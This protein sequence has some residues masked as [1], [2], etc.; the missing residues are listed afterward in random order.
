[1]L[2]IPVLNPPRKPK[3]GRKKVA[4][5]TKKK[6]KTK[7]RTSPVRTTTRKK[8]KLTWVEAARVSGAVYPKKYPRWHEKAGEKTG[9]REGKPLS[10]HDA[11]Q[12]RRPVIGYL[13]RQMI[14]EWYDPG[15]GGATAKAGSARLAKAAAL[16]KK[17]EEQL[18]EYRKEHGTP[19][20]RHPQK[21]K[22]GPKKGQ[23]KKDYKIQFGKVK[24]RSGRGPVSS[25]K[26]YRGFSPSQRQIDRLVA[27]GF[28]GQLSAPG[29][30][31]KLNKPRRRKRRS[32]RTKTGRFKKV[33]KNPKRRVSKK[34]VRRKAKK[35]PQLWNK[36]KRKKKAKRKVRRNP[37]RKKATRRRKAYSYKRKAK[38]KANP[39]RRRRKAKKAVKAN[40]PRR[41][42]RRKA[43]K[44]GM[45]KYSKN[46]MTILK[47]MVTD[48]KSAPKWI[49]AGHILLGAGTTAAAAG[50]MLTRTP[51][52]RIGFL[53][54]R[55]IVGS[56]ARL[57]LVGMTAGGISAAGALLARFLGNPKLL[58]GARTNLLIGGFA[59]GLA[60]FLYEVMPGTAGML[61]IPQVS[62]PTKRS[63]SMEGWG[64]D[65]KYGYGGMSGVVSPEELVAGESLARNV[66]EFSG[67]NDWMELSGLGSSG[68]A[69]VPME[70]LRGYPGQYGGGMNDWVELT[71]NNALVQAGF[72][73]GAEGF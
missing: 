62:A 60:N 72:N 54:K 44:Y 14:R 11:L 36:P 29:G 34:K 4:T 31:V 52:S 45:R 19:W 16:F 32:A 39:K 67:M 71:S 55:G 37:R 26:V 3:K 13:T 69:P 46:P 22:V 8:G 20:K 49:T 59:Y 53:Q 47:G 24:F 41:R 64:P 63:V 12:Y 48:L 30:K 65:Y 43:R 68:G 7:R 1:M 23:L 51:L 35:A 42:R 61:M 18:A 33:R 56:L 40:R 28:A 17:R 2:L 66:N 58:R 6:A 50:F 25:V 10:K 70:D 5:K 73:P 57:G 27:G 15:K 38:V 21:Y 9:S